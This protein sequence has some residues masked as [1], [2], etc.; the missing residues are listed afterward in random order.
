MRV[1]APRT[2]TLR[3]R[4][5]PKH[6]RDGTNFV[7]RKGS[8]WP[9][10]GASGVLLLFQPKAADCGGHDTVRNRT[11]SGS[12]GPLHV[13]LNR[14]VVRMVSARRI[15]SIAFARRIPTVAFLC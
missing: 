9:F 12:P 11:L 3:A 14:G 10:L 15:P 4:L 5:A 2:I 8:F 1:R 6:I 13:I 7:S